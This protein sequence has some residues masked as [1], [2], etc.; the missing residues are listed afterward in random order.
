MHINFFS[1]IPYLNHI[2]FYFILILQELNMGT[3][4]IN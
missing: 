1:E 4:V 3:D 2:L